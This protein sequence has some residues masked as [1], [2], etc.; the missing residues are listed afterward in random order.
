LTSRFRDHGDDYRIAEFAQFALRPTL[1][2]IGSGVQLPPAFAALLNACWLDFDD[3]HSESGI[4]AFSRCRV[5]EDA[6]GA[7]LERGIRRLA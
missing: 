3:T 1:A 6:R 7:A 2:D 5:H 4:H